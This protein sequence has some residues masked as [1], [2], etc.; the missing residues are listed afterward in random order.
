[1]QALA[2]LYPA[3][4]CEHLHVVPHEHGLDRVGHFGFF[5]TRNRALWPLALEWLAD[6]AQ[7]RH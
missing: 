7:R 1:M 5:L 4:T 2:A 6:R 3:A